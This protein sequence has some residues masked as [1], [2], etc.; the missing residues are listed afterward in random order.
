[1]SKIS[2]RGSA[3]LLAAATLCLSLSAGA[4][5]GPTLPGGPVLTSHLPDLI[6]TT[7]GFVLMDGFVKWGQSGELKP[8]QAEA[9]EVGPNRDLCRIRPVAYRTHNKGD[10]DAGAFVTKT[11]VG[12][13]LAHTHN[14]PGGLDAHESINWHQYSLDLKEGMNTIRVVYDA[15][16]QVAETDEQNSFVIHANVKIDCD[17]DG[18]IAGK[19]V[20]GGFKAQPRK[21]RPDPDPKPRQLRLRP[22]G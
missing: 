15:N 10:G 4:A 20:S 7:L 14:V 9:T 19:P 3:S 2:T 1:M 11:Y 18:Y 22:R 5:A 16:K 6:P 13:S 21:P 12:A 8:Y 17:G